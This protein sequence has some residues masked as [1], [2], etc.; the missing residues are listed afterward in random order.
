MPS[1]LNSVDNILASAADNGIFTRFFA[2]KIGTNTIANITSGYTSWGRS[3]LGITIPS[4]GT[5][6]SGVIFPYIEITSEDSKCGFAIGIEYL[7]G[8]LTV[9]GNSF[10]DGVVMPTKTIKG[11]SLQTAAQMVFAVVTTS[12]T[13]TT[14]T[15]TTTYKNQAG[16][17]GKVC[18]MTLPTNPVIDSAYLLTPNL[19]NGDTGIQDITNISIDTGS[20]GVISIYGLL[21]LRMTS[22]APTA[23]SIGPYSLT[24][25]HIMWPAIAGEVIGF[26]RHIEASSGD[27]LAIISGV[28]DN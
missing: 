8:T 4:L 5:G 24:V 23:Q 27:I 10:A 6:L 26:Y 17:G 22:C 2:G 7:L 13:A 3:Q 12:L 1:V 19:A 14:P 16:T 25:P 9:S 18:T 20:A 28:A 21:V 15:L 11:V